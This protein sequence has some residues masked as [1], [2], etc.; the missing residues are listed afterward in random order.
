MGR[1]L[2]LRLAELSSNG[3]SPLAETGPG[4]GQKEEGREAAFLIWIILVIN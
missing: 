4:E 1:A 3:E 2:W